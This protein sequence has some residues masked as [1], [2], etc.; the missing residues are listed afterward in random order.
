MINGILPPRISVLTP[1]YNHSNY[2]LECIESLQRQTLPDWEQIIIDDGSTDDTQEKVSRVQDG[3]ITYVRQ[4]HVGIDNLYKSYNRGLRESRAEYVAILEGDDLWPQHKLNL[5]LPISEKSKAAVTYGLTAAA[6]TTRQFRYG[7]FHMMPRMPRDHRI[8]N[9]NPPGYI[10]KRLLFDNFIPAVTIII[11]RTAL[12]EC[13]GFVQPPNTIAVD[14]PTLLALSLRNQF[15]FIPH[16]LG[17]SRRHSQS[18][19]FL[20]NRTLSQSLRIVQS[21]GSYAK[22]LLDKAK[23]E[24]LVR[25]DLLYLLEESGNWEKYRIEMVRL[26]YARGLLLNEDWKEARSVFGSLLTSHVRV[27]RVASI[28]GLVASAVHVDLERLTAAW[29]GYVIG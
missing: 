17:Y 11:K 23:S 27:I 29:G 10:L 4:K 9:N 8:L 6:G 5:Q 12:E 15:L 16:I 26:D 25:G 2:I 22:Q 21:N 18:S 1:T 28:L 7:I 19:T 20:V 24:G 14:F 13:R 3:R